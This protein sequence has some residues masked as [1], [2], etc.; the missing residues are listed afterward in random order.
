MLAFAGAVLTPRFAMTR[1]ELLVFI[2][3][4]EGA[5]S[6]STIAQIASDNSCGHPMSH[7]AAA[8]HAPAPSCQNRRIDA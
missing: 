7:H 3:Y 5:G 2:Q 1:D 4:D 8:W 6:A